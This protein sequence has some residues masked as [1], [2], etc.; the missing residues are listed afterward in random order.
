MKLLFLVRHAKSSWDDPTLDD[1]DRPL[2]TRGYSN[3]PTM[4]HRLDAWQTG[5]QLIATSTAL[6]ASETAYHFA[7][8]LT[9]QPKLAAHS[10]LY[11][12]SADELLTFIQGSSDTVDRL[13]I[14]CH[15]PAITDLANRFGMTVE[16]I[17]T[18]GIAVFRFAADCWQAVSGD[19]AILYF[20]DYPKRDIAMPDGE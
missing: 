7:N 3:L 2:N 14:V 17:P 11:S 19:Q 13:M 6:R 20:Y 5:P 10:A 1:H 12:E 16:N 9:C 18:C 15:N 8:G 4:I